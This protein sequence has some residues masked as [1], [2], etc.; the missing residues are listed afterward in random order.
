MFRILPFFL[1][2]CTPEPTP[3]EPTAADNFGLTE[4]S[5]DI[6][7]DNLQTDRCLFPFPTDHYL[8]VDDDGRTFVD[9]HPDAMPMSRHHGRTDPVHLQRN[10]GFGASSPIHFML[11]GATLGDLEVFD[12][13]GSVGDAYPTVLVDLDDGTVIPHWL[14]TD[15]LADLAGETV[16]NIRPAVPLP[17]G[18]RVGV[19]VRHLVDE[20]GT[21][22]P[23][24]DGFLAL[25]DAVASD[26]KGVHARRAHF[27]DDLFPALAEAGFARDDLQLA[28]SFTVA[29]DA[30]AATNLPLMRDRMFAA[31]D[32]QGPTFEIVEIVEDPHPSIAF[33]VE[34]TAQ[35]PS[36]L[37]PPDE[38]GLRVWHTDN[39]GLPAA[40][41]FETVPFR[42]QIPH[43]VLESGEPAPTL[44]YGHGFLGTYAEANNGWLRDM[45]DD[46]GFLILSASMQGMQTSTFDV[47]LAILGENATDFPLL[48]HE[49][50]Q[51]VVNHLALQR[52]VKTGLQDGTDE[53]FTFEDGTSVA[54]G[55][56]WYYGNSQGGSVGTIVSATSLDID[57]AV[58]GVPGSGY[59]FL[60]QRST[61]FAGYAAALNAVFEDPLATLDWLAFVGT[62]WD[63]FDPLTFAVHLSHDPLPGTPAKQALLHVA[64]EDAQVHNEASFIL[65][66]ATDAVLMTPAVRPVDLM[67]EQPYPYEGPSAVVEVDFSVPD[68]VTP[69]DPPMDETDTHGWLRK[70]GPT[71]EQMVHFLRT[72]EVIDVCDG[73]PCVTEGEPG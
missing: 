3:D 8:S 35:V 72:G 61:V 22:V 30:N 56:V 40:D 39:D 10:D 1:L 70:W 5:G 15:H 23:A 33:L 34:M 12:I 64:K 37:L 45:A 17:R 50:M 42:L 47:W 21:P 69:L 9:I 46:F 57:R 2:A 67:D 48:A 38:R 29:T 11:P 60:L 43:S 49:G 14:E 19:G 16:F 28:W 25:R 18:H 31:L 32:Q 66:R 52:W 24:A 58:L 41:G 63:Q 4:S 51:G 13:E 36:F 55:E 59:P 44:Q 53:V 27:E 73:S 65:G 68:D 6:A 54:S 71:Q 20:A 7:C 62:G 26:L